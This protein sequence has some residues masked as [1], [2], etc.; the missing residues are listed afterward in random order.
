MTSLAHRSLLT[1]CGRGVGTVSLDGG[2]SVSMEEW[3][4]CDCAAG[5][6]GARLWADLRALLTS[7]YGTGEEFPAS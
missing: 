3:S 6:D 7:G 5:K 2:D 4:E 1:G